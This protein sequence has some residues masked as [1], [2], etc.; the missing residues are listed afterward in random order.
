ME[1]TIK[2]I[3]IEEFSK[4]NEDLNKISIYPIEYEIFMENIN[5]K[6]NVDLNVN[7]LYIDIKLSSSEYNE[8][9]FTAYSKNYILIFDIIIDK[10]LLT[11]GKWNI[12]PKK[13]DNN[14]T[15]IKLK[16]MI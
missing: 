12:L 16:D 1:K 4:V 5:K 15:C 8:L 14:V 11:Y 3:I 9:G 7:E 10:D 2:E 13:Y 6:Y